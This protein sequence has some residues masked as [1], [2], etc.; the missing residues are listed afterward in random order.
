[1]KRREF[2]KSTTCISVCAAAGSRSWGAPVGHTATKPNILLIMTD[3]QHAGMMSCAGDQW[4]NTPAMDSLSREGIRFEKAYSSNPVCV[5]SRTAMATGM[6]PDRLNAPNNGVGLKNAI[7]PS[8][9]YEHSLGKTLQRA[10]YDTFYGGKVHLC[11]LLRP[12][13]AGYDE[14]FR[15]ERDKL[16]DACL[17]FIT[18]TRKKPFFAVA[19]FINPH[20]IC[21]EYTAYKNRAINSH[22]TDGVAKLYHDALALQGNEL[23]PLP[24]NYILPDDE[25]TIIGEKISKTATT[26]ARIIRD[27]YDEKEWQIY[28]WVYRRLTEKVD[29]HIGRI[30][31]GLKDAGLE[32]NTLVVFVSDH[33]DMDAAHKLASKSQFYD[34]S[35]R[36]PFILKYPGVI[37]PGVVERS[38]PV[39][40]GLD[41]L[42]TLRDYAGVHDPVPSHLLGRSLRD[43]AEGRKPGLEDRTYVVSE[44]SMGGRMVRTDRYKYCVYDHDGTFEESLVDMDADPG[45]LKNLAGTPEFK[46]ELIRHRGFLKEWVKQSDDNTGRKYL[47]V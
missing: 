22:K 8:E 30:L 10:G 9:V 16:P 26:P 13:K 34:E 5:P 47:N 2:V 38:V 18:R 11:E 33:G 39:S 17:E 20:D 31:N 28:R 4:V 45:E 21:Y 29:G 3:Q 41:L 12:L 25:P 36:V 15:D 37:M 35:A 6:M 14:Y 23:P 43:I 44:N 32:E 27:T 1:M 42:P 40:T 24:D 46:M 7:I 19:S